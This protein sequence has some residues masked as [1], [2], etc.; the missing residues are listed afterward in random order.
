TGLTH[1]QVVGVNSETPPI[2]YIVG[3]NPVTNQPIM[4]FGRFADVLV[5]RGLGADKFSNRG[6]SGSLIL[7][8]SGERPQA[9]G[10]LF[11]GGSDREGEVTYAIPLTRVFATLKINRFIND[12]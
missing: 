12:E 11:A 8:E 10:L 7:A 1:G 9:L 6:D 4:A 5:I 3:R 2:G